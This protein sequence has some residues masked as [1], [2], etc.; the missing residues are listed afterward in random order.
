MANVQLFAEFDDHEI[1]DYLRKLQDRLEAVKGGAKEFLGI[2]DAVVFRDVI[3]HFDNQAGPD[4]PWAARKEPYRSFIEG[5]GYTNILQVT[6][7]LRNAGRRRNADLNV[8]ASLGVRGKPPTRPGKVM[9]EFIQWINPVPYA[10]A[11]DEGTDTLPKRE[12]MWLSK[13]AVENI[14]AQTLAFILDDK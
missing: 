2:L 4:G 8:G 12:F 6:G 9:N 1:K 10:R 13:E 14:S 7:R 5:E 11:H 3:E